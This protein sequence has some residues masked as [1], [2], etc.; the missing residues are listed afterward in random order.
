MCR[1]VCSYPYVCSQPC[2]LL[3]QPWLT[4]VRGQL[5]CME[6]SLRIID[7]I[8]TRADTPKADIPK[9]DPLCPIALPL[10]V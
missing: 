2:C 8:T 1:N 9:H 5:G 6:M 3:S 10:Q 7:T 4:R